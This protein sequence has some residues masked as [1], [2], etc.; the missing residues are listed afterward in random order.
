MEVLISTVT[1]VTTLKDLVTSAESS[2]LVS[3]FY[4]E[5][6]F[7]KSA[8]FS[9]STCSRLSVTAAVSAIQNFRSSTVLDTEAKTL[10]DAL[11]IFISSHVDR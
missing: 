2:G 4:I 8:H 5:I 3:I 7:M 6:K 1:G 9:S 11:V 10:T